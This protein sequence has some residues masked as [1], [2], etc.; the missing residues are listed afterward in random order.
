MG[1]I[2]P[3]PASIPITQ[4]FGQNPGGNNPAGGHTGMDF[5][6]PIGTP[7]YAPADG[8]VEW[9]DWVDDTWAD[10]L[11]WLR[12][13]ISVVLNCGDDAPSFVFGHLND[14]PL[15][16]GDRVRQGDV[17]GYTGNT[18]YSSGPHLHFEVL[19]PGYVL[20]SPTLGRSNPRDVC[21][22]YW[23]AVTAQ[24]GD[25][26]PIPAPVSTG[27]LR[28]IDISSYQAGIDLKA[29]GADMVIVKA[30]EGIG[31]EDTPANGYNWR[32]KVREA[33]AN[34]QRVGLYHFARPAK[35]ND[36]KIEAD[37]FIRCVQGVIQPGDV[38]VLDWEPSKP[39]EDP[40]NVPWALQWLDSV[41]ARLQRTPWFYSYTGVLQSADWSPVAA[42]YPL[43]HA[44]YWTNKEQGWGPSPAQKRTDIPW[45]AGV[46]AWQ[47][48][49]SGKVNG[50][51]GAVDL[52]AVYTTST[53]S[54]GDDDMAFTIH[55]L[56]NYPAYDDGPS[57]SQVLKD[58]H[59][60]WQPGESGKQT[61]GPAY[62]AVLQLQGALNAI[63]EKTGVDAATLAKAVADQLT[64][65]FDVALSVQKKA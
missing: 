40:K 10:N 4:E 26:K 14:A 52:N 12:G 25:V 3:L 63:A 54:E 43:W 64:A 62:T 5:A 6:A 1:Y 50:W 22:G 61:A 20:N 19:L 8:V 44:E 51:S 59:L 13:G 18:G 45:P 48:T 65:G 56:L 7:V 60:A 35:G 24:G 49:S 46:A 29:T 39:G 53:A 16:T 17:I 27:T 32:D 28:G 15:N 23:S 2:W 30:T 38:V 41:A 31:W 33:R 11:L 55:E 36:P 57:V 34:G 42:K 21:S 37:W 9:S 58:L 47:Y